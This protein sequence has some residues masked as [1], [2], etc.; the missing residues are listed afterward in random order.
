MIPG[1]I[2]HNVMKFETKFGKETI[3]HS[4]YLNKV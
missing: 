4:I 3:Y 1:S 2:S